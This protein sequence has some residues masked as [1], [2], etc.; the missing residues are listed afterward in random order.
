VER[1]D[2]VEFSEWPDSPEI[3]YERLDCQGVK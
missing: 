2:S 3:R 1:A